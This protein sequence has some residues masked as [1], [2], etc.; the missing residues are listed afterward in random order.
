MKGINRSGRGFGKTR[1]PSKCW[2]RE[3]LCENSARWTSASQGGRAQ[4]KSDL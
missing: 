4:K 3:S 2:Q 1:E